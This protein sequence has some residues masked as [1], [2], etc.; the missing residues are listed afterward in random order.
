MIIILSSKHC[1]LCVY[2]KAVKIIVH[3]FGVL[4]Y[5]MNTKFG[6]QHHG[7]GYRKLTPEPCHSV[8]LFFNG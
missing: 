3:C 2:F 4:K 7:R 8:K 6:V 1:G 5:Q